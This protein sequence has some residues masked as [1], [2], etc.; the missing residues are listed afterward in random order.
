MKNNGNSKGYI[1]A[2]IVLIVVVVMIY[3][4]INGGASFLKQI[5]S[6]PSPTD[7]ILL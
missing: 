1:M 7:I 3:D 6:N 4:F 5:I 2:F